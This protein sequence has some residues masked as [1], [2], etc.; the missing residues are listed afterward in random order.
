MYCTGV[1]EATLPHPRV[2]VRLNWDLKPVHIQTDIR[3]QA[4]M[5][6]LPASP[7]TEAPQASCSAAET[8]PALFEVS[9][10][11]ADRGAHAV[12]SGRAV[13]GGP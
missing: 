2:I 5:R 3:K 6:Q 10:K 7:W 13:G 9:Q 12:V 4:T 1:R 11:R 8:S